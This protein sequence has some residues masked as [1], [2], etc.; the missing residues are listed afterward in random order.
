M[1]LN[2]MI[3]IAFIT[4]MWSFCGMM[5]FTDDIHL[6]NKYTKN[7]ALFVGSVFIISFICFVILMIIAIMM[8]MM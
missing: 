7:S 4:M 3:I 6:T 2:D 5:W 1:Y 8:V